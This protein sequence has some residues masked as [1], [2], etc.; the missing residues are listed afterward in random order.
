MGVFGWGSET[1]NSHNSL[2]PL[3]HRR[4]HLSAVGENSFSLPGCSA[5]TSLEA[6]ALQH[7]AY[8]QNLSPPLSLSVA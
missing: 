5:E 6:D 4:F 7:V 3:G 2:A 8:P 1:L